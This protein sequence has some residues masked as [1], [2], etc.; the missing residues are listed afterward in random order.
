VWV[1]AAAIRLRRR[2]WSAVPI[3][4]VTWLAPGVLLAVPAAAGWVSADGLVLWAP[5][6]TVAA[7]VLG[8]VG[9]PADVGGD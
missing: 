9:R 6:V 2:G 5:A 3:H 7:V 1:L 8:M 4:A